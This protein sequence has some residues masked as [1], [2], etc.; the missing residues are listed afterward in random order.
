[1]NE[2]F[3]IFVYGSLR[4]GQLNRHILN[5]NSVAVRNDFISLARTVNSYSMIGHNSGEYP[6]LMVIDD[7][8]RFP[9][10]NIISCDF[11]ANNLTKRKIVG[12]LFVV[13]KLKLEELD[14]FEGV[15]YS[16]EVI[17]VEQDGKKCHAFSYLMHKQKS[18]ALIEEWSSKGI[19]SHKPVICGDWDA[20]LNSSPFAQILISIALDHIDGVSNYS[21]TTTDV[22]AITDNALYLWFHGL[23]QEA[24]T[25]LNYYGS[26]FSEFNSISALSSQALHHKSYDSFLKSFNHE[27]INQFDG[28]NDNIK[29]N[30]NKETEDCRSWRIVDGISKALPGDILF[31]SSDVESDEEQLHFCGLIAAIQYENRE[32]LIVSATSNDRV[33]STSTDKWYWKAVTVQITNESDIYPTITAAF[34][35]DVDATCVYYT[36]TLRYYSIFIILNSQ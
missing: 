19:R 12:E 9:T 24:N 6:Y 16:R 8:I 32:F 23:I 26:Y 11:I 2:S 20:H 15:E 13:N 36:P 31:V 33:G 34:I 18:E 3:L 29:G 22:N 1:M 17:E 14:I 25:K 7:Q 27:Y 5:S 10:T 4:S 21:V 30:E 28:D 35:G